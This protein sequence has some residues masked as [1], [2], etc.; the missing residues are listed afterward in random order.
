MSSDRGSSRPP[1]GWNEE[2]RLGISGLECRE[3][4]GEH[5]SAASGRVESL[6]LVRGVE[7]ERRGAPDEDSGRLLA[8]RDVLGVMSTS[9]LATMRDDVGLMKDG[10]GN[11][12]EVASDSEENG[13]GV[14]AL[15][16]IWSES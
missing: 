2:D 15:P 3:A 10:C 16:W 12:W 8:R 6:L 14:A 7:G 13:I 9:S 11:L 1:L 5:C 4:T